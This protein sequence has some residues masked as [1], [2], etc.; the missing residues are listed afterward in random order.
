M[1]KINP[2]FLGN[3]LDIFDDFLEEH[4]V[5]I[6]E[7]DKE[8]EADFE[9]DPNNFARLYGTVYDELLQKISKLIIAWTV[10]GTH[11]IDPYINSN[12]EEIH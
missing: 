9:C 8:M 2:E 11:H 3:I 1:D 6:P 7:S 10:P 12:G 4:N 5:R